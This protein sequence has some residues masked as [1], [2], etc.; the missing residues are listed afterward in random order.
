MKRTRTPG[1]CRRACSPAR[2]AKTA[3]SWSWTAQPFIP[4]RRPALRHGH[5]RAGADVTETLLRGE[6]VL[7]RCTAALPVGADVTGEIDWARRLDL[8]QQHSGEHLVSGLIHA[9]FGYENVGFHLGADL[10]TIDFNGEVDE[11]A[12]RSWSAPRTRPSGPILRR[13]SGIRSRTSWR[14]SHTAVKRP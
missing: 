10:V 11:Q 2:R 3:G 6:T 14:T 12:R 5:A 9:R 1:G 7:H 4:R 8:M 13:I